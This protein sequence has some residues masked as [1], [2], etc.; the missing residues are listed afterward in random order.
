MAC[1]IP[2]PG[3]L[4]F[5]KHSSFLRFPLGAGSAYIREFDRVFFFFLFPVALRYPSLKEAGSG[6]GELS[7]HTSILLIRS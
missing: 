3:A 5:L 4:A 1:K 7:N 6:N 2:V